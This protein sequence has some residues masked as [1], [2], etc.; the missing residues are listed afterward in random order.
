MNNETRYVLQLMDVQ[1]IAENAGVQLKKSEAK[2]VLNEA[3]STMCNTCESLLAEKAKE[4]FSNVDNPVE[5]SEQQQVVS[6]APQADAS[7][8]AGSQG[9]EEG[10]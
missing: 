8:E 9:P 3:Y 6:E 2:R 7:P 1:Q 4:L 5:G 10:E